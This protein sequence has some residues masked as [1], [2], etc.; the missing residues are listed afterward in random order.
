MTQT[1][2]RLEPI[3]LVGIGGFAGANLRYLVELLVPGTLVATAAVNVL[4]SFALAVIFYET[5]FAG[6]LSKP[7]RHV[8]ATGFLSSFTTYSTFVVD[9]VTAEPRVAVIYVAGSYALGFL[10]VLAGRSL[11]QLGGES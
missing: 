4:G 1:D 10:G 7:T 11:A 8:L 3:L 2:A 5:Q 9:A 6:R